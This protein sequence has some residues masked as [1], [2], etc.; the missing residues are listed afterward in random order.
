MTGRADK[1]LEQLRRRNRITE[2]RCDNSHADCFMESLE[3]LRP[4]CVLVGN[5]ADRLSRRV[6]AT[7]DI[8]F[9]NCHP[10]LLPAHRGPNPYASVLRQ[11]EAETGVTFHQID[12]DFDTGP[13]LLQQRLPVAPYDTGASL[14]VR[15]T[16]LAGRMVPQLL[17][18]MAA[19]GTP[20]VQSE[21]GEASYYPR[22]REQ[23]GLIDWQRDAQAVYNNI[24]GLNPWFYSYSFIETPLGRARL[25]TKSAVLACRP[26]AAA[27]PGTI[28]ALERGIV[29]IATSSPPRAIGLCDVC[30]EGFNWLHTLLLKPGKQLYRSSG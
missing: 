22:P 29:W 6:L 11:G 27:T 7:P 28:I 4:G 8:A 10:S 17:Q 15:C 3:R 14:R 9:I 5:W 26:D 2:V 24:R 25:L 23:D 18:I 12:A 13:V 20:V 1:Q 30:I 21:L 16:E 19:R